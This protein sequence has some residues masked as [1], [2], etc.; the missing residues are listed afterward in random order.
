MCAFKSLEPTL[1][2]NKAISP[3]CS[4][5]RFLSRPLE[6]PCK[7]LKCPRLNDFQPLGH[8]C[9]WRDIYSLKARKNSLWRVVRCPSPE[10]I[11]CVFF[12]YE[13]SLAYGGFYCNSKKGITERSFDGPV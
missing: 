10:G 2:S 3:L 7:P 8:R 13:V 5:V 1:Y 4:V 9:L 11:C 6:V 12:R